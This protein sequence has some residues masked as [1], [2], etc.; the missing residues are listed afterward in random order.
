M[1]AFRSDLDLEVYDVT[2]NEVQVDVAT[3]ALDGTVRLAVLF[4]QEI[5]LSADDA[6][7]VAQSLLR[8][9]THARRFEPKADPQP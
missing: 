4:T 8:A 5:Y 7:R 2:G 3:N 1:S 6:K 9:A